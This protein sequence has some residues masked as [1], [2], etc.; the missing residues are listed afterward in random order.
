MY[1][2]SGTSR[3]EKDKMIHKKILD[4]KKKRIRELER[5]IDSKDRKISRLERK[6]GRSGSTS[7]GKHSDREH[8]KEIASTDRPQQ[9]AG[10]APPERSRQ[11]ESADRTVD[12]I[13]QAFV[14]WCNDAGAAMVDRHSMFAKRLKEG[15][16]EADL[17]RIF[18][19]R[20]AAGIVFA[21][22]VQD[23]VE[24][25]LVRVDGKDFLLPQPQ[26]SGFREVEECFQANC[27]SPKE[28][29]EFEPA[30]LQ[31]S[32]GKYELKSEGQLA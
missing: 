11:Q 21:D 27:T 13:G 23:A 17:Q 3:K 24:Y 25:W 15:L 16:P 9:S 29:R 18:R 4:K 10:E 30:E 26:R 19:E 5:E 22:D 12:L 8:W 31:S 2:K 7:S 28:I 6:S 1:K 14:N 20:N 32:G